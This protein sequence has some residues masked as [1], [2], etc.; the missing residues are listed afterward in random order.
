M[1][2]KSQD[3]YLEVIRAST[4]SQ[5]YLNRQVILLLSTLGVPDEVFVGHLN[6]AL[7]SLDVKAVLRTLGKIY[8]KSLKKRKLRQ[9]VSAELD[10]FFGPSKIFGG[11]FKK[12]ILKTFEHKY[13]EKESRKREEG[14][15]EAKSRRQHDDIS[16]LE[17]QR[18]EGVF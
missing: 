7:K 4:F 15:E 3:R 1:K 2:F 12:A 5:G 14:K 9:D 11:I 18:D 13:K 17:R 6:E 10:L 16:M 8:E